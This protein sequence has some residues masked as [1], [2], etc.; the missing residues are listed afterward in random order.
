MKKLDGRKARGDESRHVVLSRAVDI[1]SVNGLDGLTIG[2]L[3]TEVSASKSGVAALF[4]SKEQLQLAVIEAARTIFLNSVIEPAREQSRGLYR[5]CTILQSWIDYSQGRVFEGGCFFFAVSAEFDSRS[6]IL[7]DAIARAVG[8]RDAYILTN[9]GHA[10]DQG[11][12]HSSTDSR[13]LLF[14]LTAL[15]EAANSYSLLRRSAEPYMF[16]RRGIVTR[17]S[18]SGGD[19]RILAEAGLIDLLPR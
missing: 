14:E 9:I 1:A 11:E 17:L 10:A 19:P 3:A 6:G 16:A 2:R 12:L 7:H 4:G 18:A 8:D 5:L 15:V 13:Q